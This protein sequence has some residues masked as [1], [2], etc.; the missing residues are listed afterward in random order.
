MQYRSFGKT[1]CK[2][3]V[4]GF[5]A[6]RMPVNNPEDAGDINEQKAIELIRYAIDSGVNYVDTAFFYHNGNSEVLVGKALKDGYREKTYVATK[7]PMGEVKSAEDFDRL[8]NTQL[9]KLDIEY[10]DFYLFHALNRDSWKKVVDFGL[11]EKMKKAKAEGKVR[12]IGFSFHDDLE[13]FEQILDEYDGCEFCQI[14][15]NFVDTDYQAG[16]EGLKK[17]SEMGLGV[18]VMEPLRGGRLASIPESVKKH[19][20]ANRGDVDNSLNFIWNSPEVSLLLSGMG[21]MEQLNEN[22]TLAHNS[23]V[24]IF[25]KEELDG[26]SEAKVQNDKLTLVPCTKCLYCQPCPEGVEIPAIFE[27]YNKVTEGGRRL[28]KEIMPDID[29]KIS[30]CVKCGKCEKMCP[31]NIEIIKQLKEIKDKF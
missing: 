4:L 2:V 13:V 31:Q 3:S 10:I 6:M 11:I 5:G 26:F 15:Y 20:P 16:T 1:G 19:L 29:D 25:S 17:A 12:H 21:T 18:V 7:L 8:L 28:V 24:G 30:K 27:A 14:Q 22:I 23:K 9:Q